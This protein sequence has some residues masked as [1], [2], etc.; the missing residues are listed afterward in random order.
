MPDSSPNSLEKTGVAQLFQPYSLRG[1][2]FKN[3][4]VI[5]PMCQYSAV[6]GMATDWHFAHHSAFAMGG[7]GCIF[8][9][10]AAVEPRGRI[11]HGDLGIWSDA[12]RDALKPT[13]R[14]MKEQG[15]LPAI[16]IAHAGRKASTQRPWEGM[17][18][19]DERDAARG[20]LPWEVVAPS[21]VP[22]GEGWLMPAELTAEGMGEIRDN[23]VAAARRSDEAGFDVVEIHGAHGYLLHSFLSPISN[24]RND[25]YGGDLAGRIRFPLEVAAAVREAWPADKPLFYRI[26]SIDAVEEGGWEL[27]DSIAFS[28]E[29]KSLGIDVIDCSSGGIGGSATAA[30]LP[31]EPGFQV[32]FAEAVRR[33]AD[34]PTMAVGLILTAPQAEEILERGQ[35]DLIA[36]AREALF[37]PFWPRHA[38]YALGADP[39]FE[40]WPQQY[41][42]WLHRREQSLV[43][44]G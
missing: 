15:A 17:G 3:R 30:R 2:T 19:L 39:Q 8:F 40:D 7:A 21:A 22:T 18:P 24:L 42:W 13:I 27:P 32:P 37:D 6:E 26:S 36:I 5:A 44:P 20:E 31:R 34:I 9:E 16:Q 4:I 23:F 1:V 29:L 43:R 25:D 41:G 12:Q 35:A 38:A 14:F 11:T 33:E 28:K 10:A